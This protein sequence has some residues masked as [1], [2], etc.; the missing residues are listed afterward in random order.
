MLAA[1]LGAL[2]LA[3]TAVGLFGLMAYSVTQS[4]REIGVRMALGARVGDVVL[5]T[6]RQGLRLISMPT[7]HLDWLAD[8]TPRWCCPARRAARVDPIESLRIDA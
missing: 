1:G 8:R 6:V 3:L 2:A 5:M 7:A 4:T